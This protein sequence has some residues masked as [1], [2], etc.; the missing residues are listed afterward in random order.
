LLVNRL[1]PC[2]DSIISPCQSAFVPGRQIH[3]NILL[4]CEIMNKFKSTKVKK[5]WVTLKLDMEKAYDRVN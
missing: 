4:V 5:A 2:L 3:D 1:R